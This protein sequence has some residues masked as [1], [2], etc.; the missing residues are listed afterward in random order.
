MKRRPL[1]GR[2]LRGRDLRDDGVGMSHA[3][4]ASGGGDATPGG[5]HDVLLLGDGV[6]GVLLGDNV[7]FLK[8]G[9]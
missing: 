7:S 3:V 1:S 5:F 4:P 9:D 2:P 8:L 6:S